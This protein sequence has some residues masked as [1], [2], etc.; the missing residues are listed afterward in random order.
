MKESL[1]EEVAPLILG[2]V[3][4]IELNISE[5]IPLQSKG[6]LDI[7]KK[8]SL[9]CGKSLYTSLRSGNLSSSGGGSCKYHDSSN[10]LGSVVGGTL[11]HPT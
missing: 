9:P 3:L 8:S 11:R 7:V 4:I 6:S 5:V 2:L 10:K 1:L